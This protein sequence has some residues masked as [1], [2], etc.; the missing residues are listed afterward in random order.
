[1]LAG[2]MVVASFM[3]AHGQQQFPGGAR[4]IEFSDPKGSAVTSNLNQIAN[5]K[6][7]FQNLE[8]LRKPVEVFRP[9]SS[10]QGVGTPLMPAPPSGVNS[11]RLRELLERRQDWPFLDFEDYHSGPTIEEIFGIPAY[12]PNGEVKEKQSPLERYYERLERRSAATTHRTRND[13][14]TAM[15]FLLGNRNDGSSK[16]VNLTGAVGGP[17]VISPEVDNP[18]TQL[19]RGDP[20]NPIFPEIA[21]PTGF[22][23]AF[24]QVGQWNIESPEESRAQAARLEEYKRILYHQ[25]LSPLLPSSSPVSRIAPFDPFK[26]SPSANPAFGLPTN[27]DPVPFAPITPGRDS[28]SPFPA[29]VGTVARPF[30][31]PEFSTTVPGLGLVPSSPLPEPVRT[32]VPAPNFNIPKRRF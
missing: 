10:L 15:E 18:L 21:R 26:S 28:S 11:K 29:A 5:E 19:L 25:T 3:A 6:T 9:G 13:G 12:G 30:E 17:G 1:M 22:S 32:P 20:R 4:K 14:R 31:L 7:S 27:P 8:D 24:G 2:T 23:G 16:D